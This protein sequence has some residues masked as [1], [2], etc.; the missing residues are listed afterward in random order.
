VTA[1]RYMLLMLKHLAT[2][3]TL[4]LFVRTHQQVQFYL[5]LPDSRGAANQSGIAGSAGCLQAPNVIEIHPVARIHS[6]RRR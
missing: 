1:D 3:G 2:R 5:D 4:F 6:L